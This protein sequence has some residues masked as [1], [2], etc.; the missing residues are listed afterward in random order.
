MRRLCAL[1][2]STLVGCSASKSA[3]LKADADVDGACTGLPNLARTDRYLTVTTEDGDRH[4]YVYVPASY[5][6]TQ[7][8]PLV[9]SYHG[10]TSNAS[11]QRLLDGL[12]AR[13][14]EHGF[15]LVHPE[16]TGSSQS[17]NAGACCGE[18]QQNGVD[19]VA[20]T[21][22]VLDRLGTELCIDD[23]RVFATGMSNGAFMSYRLACELS[24]R[25]AAIAPVAGSLVLAE[26]N[27]QRPIPLLHFHGTADTLVPYQ[28]LPED[29]LAPVPDQVAAWAVANGCADSTT[30][31][32]E[33]GDA[34]CVSHD[35]CPTRGTTTL[36]TIADGGHTWPG[37]D[38]PLPFGKTSTDISASDEIWA[39]FAA[40]DSL[41]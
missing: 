9:L 3:S 37:S 28:G 14:D 12:Q 21:I 38:L 26:C 13:A 4:F 1:V 31:I 17:W 23:H 41:P 30:S 19:D 40:Q 11:Q 32:Y 34:H 33:Q 27:P 36:C 2:V 25:I 29:G 18:A 5:Q 35:A 15:I 20:F 22:A 16:G 8:T 7:A 6:A 39:F 10:L 24:D